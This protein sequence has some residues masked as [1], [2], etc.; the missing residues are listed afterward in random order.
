MYTVHQDP[1]R[2]FRPLGLVVQ[3][4]T[5]GMGVIR[6]FV[7]RLKDFTGGRVGAYDRS[8][9][10]DLIFPTLRDLSDQAHDIYTVNNVPPDAIVGLMMNVQSVPS[11]GMAMM[12]ITVY[13][14]AVRYLT[15]KEEAEAKKEERM[16]F[17]LLRG[18]I[19]TMRDF[20]DE[21]RRWCR[22]D[23]P[24]ADSVGHDDHAMRS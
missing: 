6:D 24:V 7:A 18:L 8:V 13:G 3:H 23:R 5:E 19:E 21:I 12:Q 17:D 10:K 15:E 16:F 14:T 9:S 11:K 2:R 22:S 1:M 20:I 4:K